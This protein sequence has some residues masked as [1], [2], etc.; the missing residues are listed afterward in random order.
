MT[1]LESILLLPNCGQERKWAN[2]YTYG[3]L[4][5]GA[6]IGFSVKIYF[7]KYHLL[8]KYKY[9]SPLF[10][11]FWII[12]TIFF[13]IAHLL[14]SCISLKIHIVLVEIIG[15]NFLTQKF[16]NFIFNII[17]E[18]ICCYLFI[19]KMVSIVYPCE[20]KLSRLYIYI[21]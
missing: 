19:I 7:L 14:S 13:F 4:F 20:N 15:F 21:Y 3:L 2:F 9:C 18:M 17:I 1:T 11:F 16:Y 10:F 6:L 5:S 12:Y 8:R